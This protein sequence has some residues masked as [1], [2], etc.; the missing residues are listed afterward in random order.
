MAYFFA[1]GAQASLAARLIGVSPCD[2]LMSFQAG[3]G[4]RPASQ[5]CR[6][7]ALAQSYSGSRR[8]RTGLPLA[9][10]AHC[11]HLTTAPFLRDTGMISVSRR[12]FR[13]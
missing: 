12:P 2:A 7:L 10:G 13:E 6:Y 9:N 8:S 4:T 11:S 5:M 3:E 1:A